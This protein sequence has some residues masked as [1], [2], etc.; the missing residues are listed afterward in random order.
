MTI[1][2]LGWVDKTELSKLME[3]VLAELSTGWMHRR[4]YVGVVD[5]S[6]SPIHLL[7]S[8]IQKLAGKM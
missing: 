1:S 3:I 7:P 6:P 4:F 5:T 2:D 8:Q